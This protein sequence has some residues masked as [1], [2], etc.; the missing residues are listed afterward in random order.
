MQLPSLEYVGGSLNASGA[1]ELHLPKLRHVSGDFIVDGTGLAHLPPSLEHI[2][3][4]AYI[5]SKE[6]MTLLNE[7][8]EAKQKGILKGKVV[9][10]GKAY[11]AAAQKPSWKFW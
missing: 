7:L 9:V 11:E 1:R 4:D 2:G 8:L 5:S 10:D 6:P 3:G